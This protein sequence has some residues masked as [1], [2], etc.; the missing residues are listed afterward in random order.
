MNTKE[1][2]RL[3]KSVKLDQEQREILVGLILGDGHLETQNEGKTFRLKVEHSINQKYYV[4]W[5]Y[6]KFNNLVLT[7]PQVKVQ[8]IKER[9]YEKYWFSTI[10]AGTF[11]FYGRQFYPNGKK[12]VPKMIK[13]LVT[14]LSLAIWFMDDGSIK[15]KHHKARII[16]TQAFSGKD[17]TRL[18]EMLNEK[19]GIKTTLRKQ[20]EGKQIYIGSPYVEKFIALI[21]P[22]VIPS[23]EYKIK[24][25]QLPKR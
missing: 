24:L 3:A 1:I 10:S 17:L 9:K 15:S 25:T 19:F 4:E 7:V 5:L 11:R 16:N 13:K 23:M 2:Q 8:K 18:Q 6:Q 12:I 21:K 14:P 22:N 20:K